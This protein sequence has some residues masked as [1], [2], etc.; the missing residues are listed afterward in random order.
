[1][2][3]FSIPPLIDVAG[4]GV[5]IGIV[6]AAVLLG[7]ARVSEFCRS[8]A[9]VVGAI[10]VP[11]LCLLGFNYLWHQILGGHLRPSLELGLVIAGVVFAL[12]AA[13]YLLVWRERKWAVPFVALALAGANVVGIPLLLAAPDD[14]STVAVAQPVVSQLD[15]VLV[16]PPSRTPAPAAAPPA[17]SHT[18]PGFD[19]RYSV[20]RAGPNRTDWLLFDSTD[21]DAVGVAA[22]GAGPVLAGAPTLR[23]G[24]DHV[25][26]L[27][28]GA[29]DDVARWMKIAARIAPGAPVAVLLRK[30][31]GPLRA[32]WARRVEPRG[33]AVASMSELG[34]TSIADAAFALAVQ[35][36]TSSEE[37]ALALRFRPVLLFD[38]RAQLDTPLD[39]DAFLASG[40]VD[41]CHD[42]QLSGSR[43]APVLRASDL[44]NGRTHLLIRR[45]RTGSD[46]PP[47][48]IY[49]HPQERL[50]GGRR[51]VL[52][53][54]WWYLD[55][56]PARVGKGTSCGVGLA[57]PGKTCFD[58]QSDWEGMT[59]VVDRNGGNPAVVA[60]QYAQ[61]AAVVRYGFAELQEYWRDRRA[62]DAP[63][64]DRRLLRNLPPSDEL[65]HR[66]LAFVARGTHATY[67]GICT[68]DCRQVAS[69]L[70]ENSHDGLR[71]WPANDTAECIATRC[72]RLLPTRHSGREPALWNAYDGV[73]GDRRCILR[74]AFCSAELSPGSP[75][76][77]KRYKNPLAVNGYVDPQRRFHA[78]GT[79]RRPCPPLPAP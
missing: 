43:C 17:E 30:A 60:V 21:P 71:G 13:A 68:A 29:A 1:M 25:V 59:V 22:L 15:I 39:I 65:E 77:Q 69:D 14:E 31:D 49:V 2:T 50:V 38:G 27:V 56:N 16:V 6:V 3:L 61:H 57:L 79:E 36:P 37:L 75:A 45:R 7:L 33:G 53:D 78:C 23:D 10:V 48:A 41:L 62:Q 24:A 35:A 70:K 40:R 18:Q 12:A 74:G 51:L 47:S 34:T 67:R 58:H 4:W 11:W 32:R 64:R 9:E 66:P 54:Y 52:L 26:V 8:L 44:V 28:P 19:T 5:A 20:A 55:D 76:T 46:E 73:W 63:W 42:D 72:V